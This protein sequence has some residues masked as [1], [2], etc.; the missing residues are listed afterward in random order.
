MK[1]NDDYEENFYNINKDIFN[2]E[3]RNSKSNKKAI[4]K[5]NHEFLTFDKKNYPSILKDYISKEEW[6]T[7]AEEANLVIGN[8]YQLRK[9]EE[10]VHLPKYMNVI[11][12]TIFCFS[13]IDFIFLIIYT[14]KESAHEI[15]IY[16]ALVLILVSC[17]IIIGLMFYNYTR[18]LKDEKKIDNFIIEGMDEYIQNLNIKYSKIASFKYNHDKLEIECELKN[19]KI[20]YE[21]EN[22]L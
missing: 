1:E 13:L 12:W 16:S 4:M 3:N 14:N 10:N 7:I 8:A 17:G 6:Q 9:L 15:I 20:E 5:C 2:K 22:Q 19:K 21:I 18:E 11:F